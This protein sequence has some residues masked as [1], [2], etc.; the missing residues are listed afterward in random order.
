[1]THCGSENCILSDAAMVLWAKTD[2]VHGTSAWSP[3]YVHLHDAMDMAGRLYDTW[4]S[5]KAKSL[6]RDGTGLDGDQAKMLCMFAAGVH[7]IGKA[8][9][10]FQRRGGSDRVVDVE[11][12]GLPVDGMP[13]T[14]KPRR[15][16]AVGGDVLMRMLENEGWDAQVSSAMHLRSIVAL[17]HGTSPVGGSWDSRYMY[18]KPKWAGRRALAAELGSDGWV[19]VQHE[20]VTWVLSFL[21][22][23]FMDVL[24]AHR[25]SGLAASAAVAV[26]SDLVI[27][28]DWVASNTRYFA[29]DGAVPLDG[30]DVR[31]ARGW[32]RLRF[33][34]GLPFG[35]SPIDADGL[36]AK[37]FPGLPPDAELRPSQRALVEMAES[38]PGPALLLVE[39][40]TGEG[41]TEAM[42]MAA[43][44][45]ARRFGANGI[46][47]GLPTT[48][49]ANAMFDRMAG[50]AQTFDADVAVNL[51]HGKARMFSGFADLSLHG[52]DAA[53]GVYVHGWF[54][55]PKRSLLSPVCVS[56]VDQC[57]MAAYNSRYTLLR[58]L[59][60]VNK[61]VV[62]DEVHSYDHHMMGFLC[63]MLK[64]L[65]QL[66]VPVVMG[67]ATLSASARARLLESYSHVTRV[68]DQIDCFDVPRGAD[69]VHA[70]YPLV[71]ARVA[72]EKSNR[73]MAA[74]P[75][76]RS[77]SY[78]AC[79]IGDD[80]ADL[81]GMLR[82]RL[83]DGGCALVVRDTVTRAQDAYEAL[84]AEFGDAVILT[85]A[86][87][88]SCDR[89]ANDKMLLD[90]MGP[91]GNRPGLRIVVA[92]QVA[93]SSLDVDFDLL[94]TDIAPIDAI[95]QRV[96]RLFRHPRG[97]RPASL[98]EPE[99]LVT[100]CTVPSRESM[101]SISDGVDRVYDESLL[102]RT[103]LALM[104]HPFFETPSDVPK[105]QSVVY[106][107]LDRT[108]CG[109]PVGWERGLDLDADYDA[110]CVDKGLSAESSIRLMKPL[111][112]D[113]GTLLGYEGSDA[114]DGADAYIEGSIGVRDCGPSL[115]VVPLVDFGN[116]EVGL[117]PH[118][119]FD[120]TRSWDAGGGVPDDVVD[121]LLS[122][123]LQLPMSLARAAGTDRDG[124]ECADVR[125]ALESDAYRL[126]WGECRVLSHKL[127]LVFD[128]R[129]EREVR[130][131]G[132]TYRL[133]YTRDEGLLVVAV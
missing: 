58:L 114:G 92:T 90:E 45:L 9:P 13:C 112:D 5:D 115:A 51:A 116:G 67:S 124:R 127:P 6:I 118:V 97:N 83:S 113:D 69:D 42:C 37:R 50:W 119:A 39:A 105:L 40:P 87:F 100:G 47:F 70:A 22:T 16:D 46:V 12:A 17:H 64:M 35:A 103:V 15:H 18:M 77:F 66:G 32:R 26:V 121:A 99:V 3:L 93:E 75:S 62:I 84:R 73:Y 38:V 78:R 80:V 56:T 20:L 129:L 36:F 29:L 109:W 4:L 8:T 89:V 25:M 117:L 53:A 86:R 31:A 72:G 63:R 74:E 126:H 91:D 43:E 7:D 23:S 108:R 125:D 131:G 82:D 2:M 88:M 111:P 122:C 28:A 48:V 27:M 120:G 59:G 54:C 128:E 34:C 107:N 41:K 76:S 79:F 104:M 30:L 49:T 65:G 130:H 106:G 110:K 1:M 24:R 102:M 21:D 123:E 71:S 60:L 68:G 61:V 44:I 11:G 98:S 95:L 10:E 57:L 96:G 14:V 85:H 19:D 94:V 101:P 33:P 132:R 55:S 81:V 133:A 52:A